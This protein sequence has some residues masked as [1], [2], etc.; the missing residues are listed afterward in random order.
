LQIYY[1]LKVYKQQEEIYRTEV[2][3]AFEKAVDRANEQRLRQI[4]T[5]FQQD[6]SDT[7]QVKLQ[8][9]ITQEGPKLTVLDP[10]TGYRLLR[11][12]GSY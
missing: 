1:G 11:K 7:T 8:Y 4:N 2:D 3:F 9:E 10:N 12:I 5:F 6:I